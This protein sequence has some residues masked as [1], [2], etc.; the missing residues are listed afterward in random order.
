MGN[1]TLM[2]TRNDG[3]EPSGR[4]DR[5]L[6]DPYVPA[7]DTATVQTAIVAAR[8]STTYAAIRTA[9]LSRARIVRLLTSLR[10]LPDRIM[11]RL[12]RHPTPRPHTAP[13]IGGLIEAGWWLVLDERPD[14]QLALGLVMW[15]REVEAPG[16]SRERFGTP[17]V[18]AVQ[19]G[20]AFRVL[21]FGEGRSLLMTETRTH[22]VDERARQRFRLYWRVISP[23]AALTRRLV[24]NRIKAEAERRQRATIRHP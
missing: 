2:T 5:S 9:D 6:L 16:Q 11:R 22:A 23:F 10:M 13:T 14:E 15:D 12:R 20:W 24:L 21:P 8:P 3:R 17:G 4:P 7:F 19:V 18:G 1:R